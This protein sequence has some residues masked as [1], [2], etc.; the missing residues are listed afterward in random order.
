MWAANN[1]R[2]SRRVDLH[3]TLSKCSEVVVHVLIHSLILV[4]DFTKSTKTVDLLLGSDCGCSWKL[5][6]TSG[7]FLSSLFAFPDSDSL[8]LD[9]LLWK[10]NRALLTCNLKENSYLS[11]EGGDV[12]SVLGDFKFLNDFS[13]GRTVTC[14]VLSADSNLLC[15]FCHYYLIFNNNTTN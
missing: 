10:Q 15:S 13:E 1:R 12:F 3:P 11:T 2:V 14:S 8:S 9:A 5:I 4:S 6:S 7:D